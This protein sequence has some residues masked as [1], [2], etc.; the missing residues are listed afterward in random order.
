MEFTE[1]QI[2]RYS[3]QIILKDVGGIGQ[4][5]L[6][7]GKVLIVGA[8][9]LGSPAALYLAAAGVGTIGIIDGDAVDL[10][11][12]QRQIIHFT[13]DVNKPK[14]ESAKEK[15]EKLNPDVKVITY[16]ERLN[17]ENIIDIIK[18]YDFI[19][20]GTDNFPTKFLI[21]DACVMIKKPFSHA[22]ILRFNGQ[23]ITYTP[24]NTCYRCIFK[25]P[26]PKGLIPTCSEAGILGSVAGVLGTIQATEALKYL[27]GI[28]NLL[29]NKLL[30]FDAFE[31]KFREISLK[32]NKNCL[33]C[34][35]NPT[36]T[37]LKEY[38]QPV[39]DL[40]FS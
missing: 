19:I 7:N 40:K 21:N 13:P 28:G 11:N 26:P 18:S 25:E 17:A 4:Q 12:L 2:E 27:L 10:T 23:T 20:D 24:G 22:G 6:L 5:K 9:G 38:E 35:D 31:M 15:I 32:K 29:I 16:K 8:G 39:C 37:E 1:S 33:I 14:V 30:T 36:I 3:R 34:G